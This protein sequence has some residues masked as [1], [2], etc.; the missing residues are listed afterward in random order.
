M[1]KPERRFKLRPDT[2][3]EVHTTELLPGLLEQCDWFHTQ[4]KKKKRKKARTLMQ[5]A[6]ATVLN[7]SN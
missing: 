6:A 7:N 5:K 3:S 1:T 2:T 4:T